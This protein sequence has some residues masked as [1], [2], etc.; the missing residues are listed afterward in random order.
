[1]NLR[2]TYRDLVTD[3][4]SGIKPR[5]AW[6]IGVEHEALLF[7]R[8]TGLRLDYERGI[9]PLL[10]A[11]QL[12]GWA[13]VEEQ[14]YLIAL[15][16]GSANITLEPGG[17]IELSGAP[18]PTLHDVRDELLA[19][20]NDLL[21]AVDALGAALIPLGLDPMTPYE[22]RPWM[23]KG[24]YKIMQ[25]YMPTVGRHGL[26]M[27]TA[28]CTIQ[29][30]LDFDSEEDM[31]RKLRVSLALQPIAIALFAASPFFEGRVTPYASYRAH[32]WE[33]TD[34]ARCGLVPFAFDPGMGFARYVDYLLSIPMYFVYRDGTYHDVAG[35]SFADFMAGR[36]TQ[37]PG[38]YALARDWQDQQTIAFPQTRLKHYLELRA[39]D[40][41]PPSHIL[42]LPAFWVGLLY[43]DANLQALDQMI[44]PWSVDEIEAF[45][46]DAAKFGLQGQFRGRSIHAWAEDWVRLSSAGLQR[47]GHDEQRYLA[48]L[49]QI[50]V[51]GLSVADQ[52]KFEF[53]DLPSHWRP[54]LQSM[55]MKA[56][57]LQQILG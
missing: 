39:A 25:D 29:V 57:D 4:A 48:P 52:L 21:P 55:A 36:L 14:G 18:L 31:V 11:L 45:Y 44:A 5:E 2:L 24:R 54:F 42:A 30:N 46:E 8:Q 56:E 15:Q 3:L 7:D 49:T 6:R 34:P 50:L 47:R 27:M 17:Q 53:P 33:H 38:E 32:I 23:P 22:E 20:F 37:M 1:M 10:Q 12:K 35:A 41:G 26:D 40:M 9:K 51:S 19:Y 43:D 13:P 16:K 28:T